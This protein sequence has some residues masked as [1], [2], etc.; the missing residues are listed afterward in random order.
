MSIA[1]EVLEGTN[2]H[3][4]KAMDRKRRDECLVQLREAGLSAKQI[5]R[6]TSIGMNIIYRA[7]RN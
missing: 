6:I 3:T 2:P 1:R 7:K 5:A 4:I